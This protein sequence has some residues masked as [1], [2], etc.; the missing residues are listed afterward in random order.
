MIIKALT[1]MLAYV[2]ICADFF[3]HSL[4][5]L[6]PPPPNCLTIGSCELGWTVVHVE[7]Q[8]LKLNRICHLPLPQAS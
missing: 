7:E 6:P 3:T 2:H 8:L 5:H 1:G 4:A